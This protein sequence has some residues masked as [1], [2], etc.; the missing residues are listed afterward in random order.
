MICPGWQYP[1]CGTLTFIHAFC[2][3]W[4]PSSERPSIVRISVPA[5]LFIGVT[6]ARIAL[7]FWWT[8]QVPHS[9]IPQPYLVPVSPRMSRRYHSNGICGSPSKA[10]ST[11][12]TLS[13]S[14]SPLCDSRGQKTIDGKDR[15]IAIQEM[16]D[17]I[18]PQL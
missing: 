2:T 15:S 14:M 13:L 4:D 11:P 6:H 7:P 3:G 5:V 18:V 12:F 16:N 17:G 9:A 1:H 8:V 10:R